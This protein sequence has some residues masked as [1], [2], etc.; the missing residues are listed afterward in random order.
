MIPLKDMFI[1]K[2]DLSINH[3]YDCSFRNVRSRATARIKSVHPGKSNRCEEHIL[4]V[5][6]MCRPIEKCP[7]RLLTRTKVGQ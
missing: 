2:I 5:G 1:K 3:K 4:L 6:Q 7:W